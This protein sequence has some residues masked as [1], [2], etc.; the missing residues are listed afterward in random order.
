MQKNRT[1]LTVYSRDNCHLCHDMIEDLRV[2]QTRLPFD[3]RI[4]EIDNDSE[5]IQKFALMVPV[6]CDFEQ[7]TVICYGRLNTN[8][9]QNN[10]KHLA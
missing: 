10:V 2:W 8:A 6:L 5:L 9:L 4:I 7:K 3:F 1:Q